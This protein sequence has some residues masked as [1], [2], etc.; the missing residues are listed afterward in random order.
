MQE[1][2]H[3]LLFATSLRIFQLE[4]ILRLVGKI[5]AYKNFFTYI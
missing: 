2:L 1:K 3:F 4:V 5:F